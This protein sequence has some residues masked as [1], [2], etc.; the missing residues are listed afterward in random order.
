MSSTN[1]DASVTTM[2]R[3]QLALFT[4]RKDNNYPQNATGTRPEQTASS[5]NLG[6]NAAVPVQ[7]YLG[8]QLIGQTA[9]SQNCA[10]STAVTLQGY[11]KK[12]P[13]S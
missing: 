10:C 12:S 8:A 3:G 4:W 2:R 6:P 9:P 1:R 13:G 11:D 5:M 7:A